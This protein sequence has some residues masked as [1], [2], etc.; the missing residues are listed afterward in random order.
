MNSGMI[1]VSIHFRLCVQRLQMP[2]F[3]ICVLRIIYIMIYVPFRSITNSFW[4]VNEYKWHHHNPPQP[5]SNLILSLARRS[6]RNLWLRN[7]ITFEFAGE[8]IDAHYSITNILLLLCSYP[9]DCQNCRMYIPMFIRYIYRAENILPLMCIRTQCNTYPSYHITYSTSSRGIC[10]RFTV[11]NNNNNNNNKRKNKKKIKEKWNCNIY[12]FSL[13][14][15]P[16]SV[17]PLLWWKQW[18]GTKMKMYQHH[19]HQ[20]HT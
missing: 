18:C 4:H 17:F 10:S 6:L 16:F 12:D 3:G 5:H 1:M 19:H 2:R 13:L 7:R 11:C 15:F 14:F 9:V 8:R 20:H